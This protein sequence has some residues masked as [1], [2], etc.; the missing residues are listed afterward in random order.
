MFSALGGQVVLLGPLFSLI[1]GVFNYYS[2]NKHII[3]K[4][5]IGNEAIYPKDYHLSNDFFNIKYN[6][7]GSSICC[8]KNSQVTDKQLMDNRYI[9]LRS[10]ELL[11]QE[12]MAL[13]N[14]I[15]DS[16]DLYAIKQLMLKS[17]HMLLMPLLVINLTKTK[18]KAAGGYRS[19]FIR[20]IHERTDIP[21]F[22]VEEA[23]RQLKE[24]SD[25]SK[26]EIEKSMD[27]FFLH[28][29][30]EEIV[31]RNSQEYQIDADNVMRHKRDQTI[32]KQ[33]K[34]QYFGQVEHD[35]LNLEKKKVKVKSDF[36]LNVMDSGNV[37]KKILDKVDNEE[38]IVKQ[39]EQARSTMREV[40]PNKRSEI[41]RK[42]T[43]TKE[44]NNMELIRNAS[45]FKKR[46]SLEG[47]GLV[48]HNSDVKLLSGFKQTQE[49][50]S[51]RQ[52]NPD[53]VEFKEQDLE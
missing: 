17:R 10:C 1:Y 14:Y 12:K 42:S 37:V 26:G 22:T 39:R 4:Y 43:V 33:T 15:H 27:S 50:E 2:M 41:K 44:E 25:A 53:D 8:K 13:N 32:K 40:D 52:M 35:E 48:Q 29:L 11:I 3:T 28:Y 31:D 30:P 21:I 9:N 46:N 49:L 47:S 23:I 45:G 38:K 19:S 6:R 18:K 16:I 34:S 7:K 36:T 51:A 20:N 24:Q 5:I